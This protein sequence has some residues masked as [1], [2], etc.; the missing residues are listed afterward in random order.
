MVLQ[1]PTKKNAPYCAH[2]KQDRQCEYA[3]TRS[4]L[5][6]YVFIIIIIVAVVVVIDGSTDGVSECVC[7]ASDCNPIRLDAAK[8]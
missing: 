3:S 1:A 7:V 5:L 2:T 4:L 6:Q 8:H